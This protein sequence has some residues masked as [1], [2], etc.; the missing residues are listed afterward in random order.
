HR[1][2]SQGPIG[3]SGAGSRTAPPADRT[4]APPAGSGGDRTRPGAR[5]PGSPRRRTPAVGGTTRNTPTR[6]GTWRGRRSVAEPGDRAAASGGE[7]GVGTVGTP[8]RRHRALCVGNARVRDMSCRQLPQAAR[9]D[10]RAVSGGGAAAA[11]GVNKAVDGASVL[12]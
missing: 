8:L 1:S 10:G 4:G 11:R 9:G 7:G 5:R 3:C 12:V 6:A 2:R